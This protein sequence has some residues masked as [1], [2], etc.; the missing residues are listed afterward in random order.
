MWV[1]TSSQRCVPIRSA[2]EDVG[3]RHARVGLLPAEQIF[4]QELTALQR[5]GGVPVAG[6]DIGPAVLTEEVDVVHEGSGE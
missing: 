3:D 5:P 6:L 4:G 2:R 1:S